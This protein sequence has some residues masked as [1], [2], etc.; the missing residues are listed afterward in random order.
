MPDLKA[1]PPHLTGGNFLLAET[2]PKVALTPEDLSAEQRLMAETAAKFMEKEVSPNIEALEHQQDGATL[3]A[4]H[5]AAELGLLG[6]DVPAEYGG[7]GLS[8]ATTVGIEEQLT[9]LGGFGV[10]CGAHCGIGTQPLLYFGTDAQ[11]KKYLPKLANA[12]WISAYALS[13]AGSGSDAL[14]LR[15]KATLTPD[16]QH[17]L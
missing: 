5:K 3:K 10:T 6:M 16:G 17:Y 1:L 7:L 11:K 12:E 9:R 2:D 14:G 8:K 13:E 4:F 15:T